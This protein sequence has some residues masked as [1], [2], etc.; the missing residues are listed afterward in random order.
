MNRNDLYDLEV[1]LHAILNCGL[2]TTKSLEENNIEFDGNIIDEIERLYE[3]VKDDN[4]A[5]EDCGI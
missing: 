1:L 2:E 3:I 4:E 5:W